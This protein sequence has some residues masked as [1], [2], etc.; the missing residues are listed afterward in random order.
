MLTGKY[1]AERLPAGP[2]GV[3]FRQILPGLEPLLNTMRQI[4]ARKRKTVSQVCEILRHH[5][6]AVLWED[7]SSGPELLPAQP[8]RLAPNDLTL[9]CHPMMEL[10]QVAERDRPFCEQQVAINWCIC[11]STI[12][13]P[14]AKTIL[15]AED[16]LGALGWRL[17]ASEM[18]AL[19]DAADAAPRGMIQNV[20]QTS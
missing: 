6:L 9:A 12:P 16:N 5:V 11:Q 15:Q 18:A 2:R 10:H 4:A 7:R 17:T 20:F 19:E 13:I 14:G 1:S 8:H 3:L